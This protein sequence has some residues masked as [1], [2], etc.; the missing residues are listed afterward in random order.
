MVNDPLTQLY[1]FSDLK[2][3]YNKMVGSKSA[4][5]FLSR[6]KE[7]GGL[8]L[9]LLLNAFDFNFEGIMIHPDSGHIDSGGFAKSSITFKYRKETKSAN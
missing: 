6:G 8:A 2:A 1:L 4:R 9:F 7:S 3:S 5:F